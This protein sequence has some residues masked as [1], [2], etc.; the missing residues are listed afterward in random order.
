[1]ALP[2]GIKEEIGGY[3]VHPAA[4]A[5]RMSDSETL[6]DLANDIKEF[7]L[8]E[9][10]VLVAYWPDAYA[11]LRSHGFE[12]EDGEDISG[13]DFGPDV[14]D[15]LVNPP[16]VLVDGRNRL[17]ACIQAGV[18]PVFTTDIPGNTSGL[19]SDDPGFDQFV[20]DWVYSKNLHR[21]HM[22]QND[23]LAAAKA[24]HAQE[25]IWAKERQGARTDLDT[26]VPTGTNVEKSD[27]L[28]SAKAYHAQEK[29]WAKERQLS[30]LK[31]NQSE[32]DTVT[33]HREERVSSKSDGEAASRAAKKAGISRNTLLRS[34]YV[35]EHAPDLAEKIE[36]GE[37][38]VTAAEK[39]ARERTRPAPTA[40]EVRSA[41]EAMIQKE[42]ERMFN[43]Y[44]TPEERV[45]LSHYF[46]IYEGENSNA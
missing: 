46:R 29:I 30:T 8:R 1:M 45:M 21:R 37:M 9:P 14:N 42:V 3:P 39:Q 34:E 11:L 10:I 27:D 43:K 13:R 12:V 18:E 32:G 6:D 19:D 31:Q 26:S 4:P 38:S 35:D 25:K 7:G 33:P 40:E 36:A 20:W 5:F 41:R 15:E 28:S 17:T 2:D 22:S 23:K 24:Y 44:N 16:M